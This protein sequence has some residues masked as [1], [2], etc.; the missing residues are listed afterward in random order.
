MIDKA[1]FAEGMG[2]LAGNFGR[3]IDGAVGQSY[4][5]ALSPHLSNEQF[6]EA[7][8]RAIGGETFWPP[9]AKLLELS[10]VSPC[11]RSEGALKH[12]S[13]TLF[14]H[15][16][17]RFIPADVAQSF[18]EQTWAAIREVGGLKEITCCTEERWPAMQRRF[19]RAYE[20][21]TGGKA[22]V[23]DGRQPH[24]KRLVAGVVGSIGRDRAT[25]ERDD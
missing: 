5:A 24:A 19:Q 3:E 18:D 9:A 22:Q 21:A 16:G 12:V 6:I 11:Q 7:V 4:Y 25:G 10:G 13:D 2:R 20:A 8:T 23:G 1:T 14:K 15:G 17:Y